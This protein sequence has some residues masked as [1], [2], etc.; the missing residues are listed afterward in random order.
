MTVV[1][2]KYIYI[3][4]EYIPVDVLDEFQKGIMFFFLHTPLSMFFLALDIPG[5][6]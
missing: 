6:N 3:N 2:F 4:I 1:L 5:L